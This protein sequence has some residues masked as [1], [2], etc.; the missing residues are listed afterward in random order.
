[1]VL[2]LLWLW[3]FF[4]S[5]RI[6]EQ[7]IYL[8]KFNLNLIWIL[9]GSPGFPGDRGDV[10]TKGNKGNAGDFGPNGPEGIEGA[11]VC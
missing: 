3:Y 4:Y 1:M 8:Y 5:Q 7:T 9:Q 2:K 10:G 11:K 6:C